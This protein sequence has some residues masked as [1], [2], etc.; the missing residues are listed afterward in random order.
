VPEQWQDRF[1]AEMRAHGGFYHSARCAGIH[2]ATA[3]RHHDR[4]PEFAQRVRE[5]KEEH[6]DAL[7]RELEEM[8]RKSNNPVSHIVRLK[9]LRPAEY[10][11]K[12]LSITMSMHADV[13]PA[14]VASILRS[15]LGHASDHTRQLIAEQA[16]LVIDAPPALPEGD[17][18]R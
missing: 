9:A 11:E 6:A 5:A 17:P 10:V 1:L 4:D 7:E 8:G 12:N 2:P 14:D 18:P 16:T 13:A 3:W 15:M